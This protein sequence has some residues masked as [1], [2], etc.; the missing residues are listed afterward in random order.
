METQPTILVVDDEEAVRDSCRQ[1]L[2]RSGLRV[3]TARDGVE[4]LRTVL[5]RHVDL[6]LLD[7]KMPG[8]DGVEFLRRARAERAGL[9]VIVITGYSSVE[10]AVECMRLG[11]YDYLTK[12]FNAET[13]RLAV[14]RAL[15]KR[16]LTE[17]NRSLRA[18]IRTEAAG[19]PLLLGRSPAIRR[20][21]E[22]IEAVA[23]TD[24]TVLVLG[25]SG[26]GKE[27][28]AQAIHQ[29][30][31]RRERPFLTVDCGSLVESLCESELYGHVRG[32]FTG[33]VASR[34][35]R[36]ELARGGTVFLDE[37]ANMSPAMQAKLLRVVQEREVVPVGGSE[38]I[39]V[40]VRVIAATHHDL[41][42][43]V[44]EGRFREDLFYRLSVVQIDIPPLRARKEDIPLLAEGL[45]QR[46]S[47]RKLLPAKRITPEAVAAML[48]YDWP[49]NVRELENH[50]ERAMVLARGDEVGPEDLQLAGLIAHE[51]PEGGAEG[52]RL[53]SQE[54]QHIRKVLELSGGHL[55]RSAELLGID[56]KTLWRKLKS[57]GIS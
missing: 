11:A 2:E 51:L 8:L 30:S 53:R 44:R 28:V 4:G 16:R 6:V 27:L 43:D 55:G 38:P 48:H 57:Y 20:V 36:F 1:T 45:L 47:R 5:Q 31:P 29:A 10:S 26:T 39:R 49:G 12:P 21:Q 32:A 25:E 56:R 35:G 40:E 46:L 9:D 13:L 41:E 15:Q 37:I 34:P 14:G 22:L 54:E 7:L 18:Q 3:L 42:A 52:L 24:T 19:G 33:A 23:P 50:L 17:E